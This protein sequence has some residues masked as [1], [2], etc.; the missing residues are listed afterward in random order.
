MKDRDLVFEYDTYYGYALLLI[1][2]QRNR[3][4]ERAVKDFMQSFN[5]LNKDTLKK[6]E[7]F[8]QLIDISVFKNAKDLIN[9]YFH[10]YLKNPRGESNK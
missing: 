1:T 9:K 7:E 10:P 2:N 5:D 6:I 3:I 4:I 8:S